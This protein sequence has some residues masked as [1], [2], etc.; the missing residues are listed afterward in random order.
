MFF[1]IIFHTF[2]LE[3]SFDFGKGEHMNIYKNNVFHFY[4][5]CLTLK[6]TLGG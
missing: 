4:Y 3:Q 1:L 6:Q 5:L 2:N